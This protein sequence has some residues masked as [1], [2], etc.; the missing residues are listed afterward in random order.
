MDI[1]ADT[2]LKTK[3]TQ[4]IKD[5]FKKVFNELNEEQQKLNKKPNDPQSKSIPEI[6]KVS[7][8]NSNS[9]S[10]SLSSLNNNISNNNKNN[11]NNNDNKSKD[12]K[13]TLLISSRDYKTYVFL[14]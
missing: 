4:K 10:K 11:N 3:L 7:Q 5:N 13:L 12:K 6:P 2:N 9:E 1:L 14:I 8:F